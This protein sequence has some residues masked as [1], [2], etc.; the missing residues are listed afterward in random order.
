[1]FPC[2]LITE[3]CRSRGLACIMSSRSWRKCSLYHHDRAHRAP[4]ARHCPNPPHFH[5]IPCSC[6]HL[7]GSL[8]STALICHCPL[9]RHVSRGDQPDQGASCRRR[10]RP[11]S[12]CSHR[13][14]RTVTRCICGFP[15]AERGIGAEQPRH[16]REHCK[17]S[18]ARCLPEQ[19]ELLRPACRA[20]QGLQRRASLPGRPLVVHGIAVTAA[21]LIYGPLWLT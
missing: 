10:A 1:M 21:I 13:S 3:D 18:A 8:S 2:R 5:L 4:H 6:A 7:A 16:R 15:G 12:H 11:S 20:H 9:R 14:F 17:G 19:L